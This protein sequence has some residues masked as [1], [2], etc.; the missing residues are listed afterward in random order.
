MAI[1]T[2]KKATLELMAK[3]MYGRFA[4]KDDVAA[5]SISKKATA[6]SGY[7]ASYQLTKNGTAVGDTINIPKD[8][9]VKSG[10]VKTCTTAG[11]PVASYKKGDKY[12]DFVVNSTD[13]DGNESHIYLLVSELV[14]AYTSGNG[15]EVSS[16]NS[17]AVKVD[18]ANANGLSVGAN[19]LA[20]AEAT[21]TTAGAMSAA[22]K[23]KVN[24]AITE[25][26]ELSLG[27]TSG[28]GNVVTGVEVSDHTIT[29]KKEVTALT[30]AD[31]EDFTQ[32]EITTIFDEAASATE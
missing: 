29:L 19:G 32:A 30:E 10:S 14:D 23:V 21:E 28:T 26:T 16:D 7:A 20:I 31:L 2:A 15:I 12:I 11:T 3:E 9:L 8:Y 22:D 24:N 27:T 5:Y 6:E 4:K 1:K 17:I 25:E 13:G 18:A